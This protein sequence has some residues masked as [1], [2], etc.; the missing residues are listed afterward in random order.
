MDMRGKVTIQEIADMAGVSKFAVSRALSGKSGVSEQ[1]REMI[2]RVAGQLGYF[3]NQAPKRFDGELRDAED[4]KWTGT[5]VILFPNIRYQNRESSYWGPVFDGVTAR[6]SQK[7]LNVVTLTEPSGDHMFNFLKPEA[8]R[9]II[10]IG[11]ISTQ[12]LLDIGQLEIPV[13]MVDHS[14][15][16]YQCDTVF[17]DNFECM[18]ELTTKLV[19]KGYRSFQ[20]V[21]NISDAPSFYERWLAFRSTLENCQ[22]EHKQNPLL[23]GP[24]A[25]EPFRLFKYWPFGELPEVFV[26]VN[27]VIANFLIEELAKRDIRV[28]EDCA[29]TGF[30]KTHSD[31]PILATV[32]V[33]KE[34]LGMRAVDQLLWRIV[35]PDSASE[36]KLIRGDVVIRDAFGSA[37]REHVRTGDGRS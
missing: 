5:I 12:V 2:L 11:S 17:A 16:A 3:K 21:G 27:D 15:P 18:R 8:I 4:R 1:T 35:N 23:I 26:C 7:G 34:L 14:D 22:I 37:V 10:T 33:N 28:P 24:E 31:S 9:G 29:V 20:F 25:D 19:S 32:D 6:L 36:K 30:D 13:V